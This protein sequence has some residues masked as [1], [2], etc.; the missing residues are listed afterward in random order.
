VDKKKTDHK[1]SKKSTLAKGSKRKPV[2][3]L[4]RQDYAKLRRAAYEYIVIQLRDQKEVSEILQV[5]EATI[6]KWSQLGHWRE[7]REARQQCYSTDADNTK[8][9]IRLLSEKRLSLE[10][11]IK[12][13]EKTGD[14]EAELKLREEARGLSDEISKHNKTLLTLDKENRVTL[15][16]YI[17]VMDDIFNA[18]RLYDEGLFINCLDFQALH[19]RKKTIELG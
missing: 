16:V 17:D 5:S 10:L 4:T 11:E 8:K 7:D 1:V 9:I 13:N 15:G 18:L 3:K 6:S 2:S 19:A 14:K 12:E